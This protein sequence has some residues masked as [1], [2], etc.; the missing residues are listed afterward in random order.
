MKKYHEINW[1]QVA[2]GAVEKYLEKLKVT[3]K[4]TV[5]RNFT[6]QDAD[7]LGE[8]VKEKMWERHKNYLEKLKK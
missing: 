1:E 6:L 4:L 8:K 2:K 5:N 7:E 3:D